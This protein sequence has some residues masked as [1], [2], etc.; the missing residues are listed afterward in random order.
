MTANPACGANLGRHSSAQ[1]PQT[2]CDAFNVGWGEEELFTRGPHILDH[3]GQN[4][5]EMLPGG[6]SSSAEDITGLLNVV[7]GIDLLHIFR[8]QLGI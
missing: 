6:S 1:V 5:V 2:L 4:L 8:E 7:L 3:R